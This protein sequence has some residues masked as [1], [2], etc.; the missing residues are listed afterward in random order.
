MSK[1]ISVII[2]AFNAENDIPDLVSCLER[3]ARKP[4]EVLF[5]DDC[6]TDKTAEM[7]ARRFRVIAMK[8]NSGPAA[9]RN[10]G[11]Q[12]ARGEYFAFLDSDCRPD[13][14]WV[15]KLERL[16]KENG[17]SVITGGYFV[18]ASTFM[19]K[20]IAALGWPCGGALGFEKMW[21]VA[22]DGSVEKISTGNFVVPRRIIEKYGGFDEEFAYCFEDA[23]FTHQL[24]SA[25]VR[26]I[27]RPEI[28][29]EH[30]PRESFW[31]FVRWHYD[32]GKGLN[33]FQ[34]KVGNLQKYW[35]L[36]LWSTR[37]IIRTYYRDPKLPLILTLLILSA[38]VQK[39][40]A[41][42]DKLSR[43]GIEIV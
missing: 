4:L 29:V 33:P 8:K 20:A 17:D 35:R 40:A 19:G 42:M 36:R 32:R 12:Y 10:M 3:Q 38:I 9:A 34:R 6:S 14:N 13:S 5:V 18:K 31:S 37:N 27:Y 1:G 23:W 39:I 22:A 28:D 15:D 43:H 41:L 7:A 24:I 26:I 2:P 25:G 11:M 21:P 16:I 30:T